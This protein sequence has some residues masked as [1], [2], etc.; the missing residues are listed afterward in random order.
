MSSTRQAVIFSDNLTGDGN[1][2][3]FTARQNVADET[4]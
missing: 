2:P 1:F 4:G 3:A